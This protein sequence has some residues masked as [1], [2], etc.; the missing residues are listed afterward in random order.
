MTSGRVWLGLWE[1]RN[2]TADN[3]SSTDGLRIT[4]ADTNKVTISSSF[5]WTVP[6][7]IADNQ[8]HKLYIVM[9]NKCT[10]YVDNAQTILDAPFVPYPM[11]PILTVGGIGRGIDVKAINLMNS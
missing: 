3:I 8:W 7:N 10:L 5:E 9:T 2:Y 1:G 4:L 6:F 11:F